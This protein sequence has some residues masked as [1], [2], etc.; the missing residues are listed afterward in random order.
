[1][2]INSDMCEI[3]RYL[4]SVV[5]LQAAALRQK[6]PHGGALTHTGACKI[7]PHCSLSGLILFHLFF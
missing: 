1:M 6:T 5:P 2:W 4:L 7:V 3:L